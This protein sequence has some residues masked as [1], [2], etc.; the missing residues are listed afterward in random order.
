MVALAML[1]LAAAV[2]AAYAFSPLS[3]IFAVAMA[4]LFRLAVRGLAGAERRWVLGILTTALVCRLAALAAIYATT[5]P[6]LEQ[7]HALFGDGR[8]SVQRSLW[9]LNEWQDVPV[10]PWYRIG[11]FGTYGVP[12]FDRFLAAV[13]WFIGPSPHALALLSVA[14]F[15]SGT[16][17]LYRLV[18]PTFGPAASLAGL[19]VLMFWPT[20]FAWSISMLK[21]SAQLL[22]SAVA[23][24]AAVSIARLARWGA[25]AA[26]ACVAGLAAV[27]IAPLRLGSDLMLVGAVIAGYAVFAGARRSVVFA[28]LLLSLVAGAAVAARQPAVQARIGAQ[29]YES[30]RYHVGHVRTPGKGY[31]AA[32]E[33][34]YSDRRSFLLVEPPSFDERARFLLRSA[35]MFVLV[36]L[37]SQVV[38]GSEVAYLPQQM[39]WNVMVVLA[40]LGTW[41]GLRRDALLTGTCVGYFF[42]AMIIIAPNSG[43]IGTLIRHRDMVVPFVVWLGS[44]GAVTALGTLTRKRYD[45]D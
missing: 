2:G 25:G 29:V 14:A 33:R 45:S 43:N 37:P 40:C 13:Q 22:L 21:E 9:M 30:L 31:H 5:N 12:A 16:V 44:L 39:A 27:L 4:L 35:A 1:P 10:G 7:F 34:F 20:F 32:D 8:Y 19:L 38:S 41:T 26:L 24:A 42:V 18:R 36:P 28:A 6:W 15:L 17:L 23:V 11:V 3:V